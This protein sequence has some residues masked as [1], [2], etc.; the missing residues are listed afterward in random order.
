MALY[1]WQRSWSV[2]SFATKTKNR[3]SLLRPPLIFPVLSPANLID[4]RI[5]GDPI[6]NHY[7]GDAALRRIAKSC[8]NLRHFAYKLD[9]FY[10]NE[11]FDGL[12]GEGILALVS[13]CRCL[14]VLELSKARRI[15]RE[16]FEEII[17]MLA[18]ANE[19]RAMANA[20]ASDD[21]DDAKFALRNITLMGY[22]FVVTGWPLR[23]SEINVECG[24]IL[25]G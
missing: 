1:L 8:C 11:A 20:V 15:G 3:F 4:L 7:L 12:S 17:Q 9:S 18:L 13:D 25:N 14:E 24:T 22:P 16:T 21:N 6:T 2:S 5:R 19:S 23:I 10:Y